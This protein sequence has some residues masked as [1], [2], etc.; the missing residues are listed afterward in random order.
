[1]DHSSARAAQREGDSA[2]GNRRAAVGGGR[3]W[4]MAVS[5]YKNRRRG[6]TLL[7]PP[8]RQANRIGFTIRDILVLE[9]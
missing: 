3:K 9:L 6:P 8:G 4:P 1:M 7:F 5:V 2:R